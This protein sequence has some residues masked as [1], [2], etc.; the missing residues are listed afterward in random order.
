MEQEENGKSKGVGI[1]F[2]GIYFN[3][4]FSI[5]IQLCDYE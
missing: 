1:Q 5:F 2:W 4:M 3:N